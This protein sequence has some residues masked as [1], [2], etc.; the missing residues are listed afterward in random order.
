MPVL[1]LLPALLSPRTLLAEPADSARLRAKAID[2][3]YNLDRAEAVA[4]LQDAIARDPQNPTLHRAM[5]AVLWLQILFQRGAVTVDH[6]LGSFSRTRIDLAAPPPDLDGAFRRHVERAIELADARVR[7]A[8][9][10]P[11]ARFDLGA[12]VGLKASHTATVEGRLFAGFRA[13]RRAYDEHERVL[14]LDPSRRDAGLTVGLYRYL[15]STLAVPMRMVA[16]VAGFGGGRHRGI[17]LLE[18][19][20]ATGGDAGADAMFALTLIY[21]REQRY[22]DAL[23]ILAELR[24]AYPRNRLVVLETG[25]T[26]LRAGR[27]QQAEVIFSEGLAVVAK[28]ARPLVPGEEQLWRYKRGAARVALRRFDAAR[29]DL[30]AATRLPAQPWVS[31]R[32]HTELARIAAAT[33][34]A[35]AAR[36]LAERAAALCTEGNDPACAHEARALRRNPHGR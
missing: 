34:D 11:Q 28:E 12:A 17:Q 25:A 1:A 6:Y 26:A 29:A 32:A 27:A 19:A 30:T 9:H 14:E 13:A 20:A 2:L 23:R 5:A 35:A 18:E 21:N 16:Y 24:R 33:G 36:S 31:G 8:P 15:V 10:D 3:A 22:D 7:A 4:L